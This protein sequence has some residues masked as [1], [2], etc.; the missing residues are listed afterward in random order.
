MPLY[1]LQVRGRKLYT[2]QSVQV[3]SKVEFYAE[4][5]ASID[6]PTYL[7]TIWSVLSAKDESASISKNDVKINR[8]KKF[9]REVDKF[10]QYTNHYAYLYM[11][12]EN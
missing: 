8:K 2:N 11:A 3:D 7:Q 10:Y 6:K 12:F 9:C 4:P 1:N 5:T